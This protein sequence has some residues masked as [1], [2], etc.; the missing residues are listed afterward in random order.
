MDPETGFR[1]TAVLITGQIG[2]LAEISP[3]TKGSAQNLE[4]RAL[5]T[6]FTPQ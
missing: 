1:T 2:Q 3:N 6:A 4:D 5:E